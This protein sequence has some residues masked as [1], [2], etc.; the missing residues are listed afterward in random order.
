MGRMRGRIA[1]VLTCLFG[2]TMLQWNACSISSD[3][4][5]VPDPMLSGSVYNQGVI[6]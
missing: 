4:H 2:M 5:S 3:S 6:E 1:D